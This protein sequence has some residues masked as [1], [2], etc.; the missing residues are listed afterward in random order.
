MNFSLIWSVLKGLK[1][2]KLQLRSLR[3]ATRFWF[4]YSFYHYFN[5]S[6]ICHR[7]MESRTK[8][9]CSLAGTWETFHH[10]VILRHTTQFSFSSQT[11]V[12][13]LK[14][15]WQRKAADH[16]PVG[17]ASDTVWF[18]S[19]PCFPFICTRCRWNNQKKRCIKKAQYQKHEVMM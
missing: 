5:T 14:T 18:V 17:V 13:M 9:C 10:T 16:V 2:A 7:A 1:D 6:F 12:W 11:H 8:C 4:Y 3:K 15:I 19:S